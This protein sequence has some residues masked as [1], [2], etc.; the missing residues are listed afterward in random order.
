MI[1]DLALLVGAY[2]VARL[3]NSWV[4]WKDD[5]DQRKGRTIVSVIAIAVI[6]WM[7]FDIFRIANESN[8]DI[9]F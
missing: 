1:P 9:G 3:F 6:V 2:C 8:A 5:D 7:V 4:L